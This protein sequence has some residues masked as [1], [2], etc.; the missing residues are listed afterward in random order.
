MRVLFEKCSK[1]VRE[2]QRREML[3]K[4]KDAR[5]QRRNAKCKT[6]AETERISWQSNGGCEMGVR[7][8]L[9][10]MR[11]LYRGRAGSK[12]SEGQRTK[13]VA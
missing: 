6:M 9:Q 12:A 8:R 4:D 1:D 11:D 7:C 2:M 5:R 10:E 3:K 13:R